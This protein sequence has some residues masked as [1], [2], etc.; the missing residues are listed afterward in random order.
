MN[1]VSSE[2]CCEERERAT[3][4]LGRRAPKLWVLRWLAVMT[5]G[6]DHYGQLADGE[7]RG[8]DGALL[9]PH[10]MQAAK[11]CRASPAVSQATQ[12]I[13]H[14]NCHHLPQRPTPLP[15]EFLSLDNIYCNSNIYYNFN[16][17][18]SY[19]SIFHFK[20]PFFKILF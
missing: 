11:S 2:S 10:L 9:R 4:S 8:R 14:R 17:H 16:I 7:E 19:F 3:R 12:V 13:I 15:L 18:N 6:G 1:W 5:V 20:F